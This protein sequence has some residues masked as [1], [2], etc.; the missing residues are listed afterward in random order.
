MPNPV[1]EVLHLEVVLI[2]LYI[3]YFL[4]IFDW[5]SLDYYLL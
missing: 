1:V 3:T 4:Y 2:K 5:I